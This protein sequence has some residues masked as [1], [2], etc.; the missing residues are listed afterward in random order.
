MSA[1]TLATEF[2]VLDRGPGAEGWM[3]LTVFSAADGRLECM[4]RITAK[5]AAAAPMLDLFDFA[6]ATLE[7]RNQ[8]RTWFVREAL[9]LRRRTGLGASYA[10]LTHACRFARVL[11]RTPVH[12]ESRATVAA[13]LERA[14]DAWETGIRPDA[15]YLKSVFL[16]ARDEGF[17]VREAW[18]RQLPAGDRTAIDAVLRQPAAGQTT[19]EAEVRRLATALEDYLAHEH[20]FVFPTR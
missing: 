13:L 14:L 15:V 16:L 2:H 11:A 3:R 9:P 8:G 4:Q 10:A 12:E 20:D 5:P 6:R 17:P 18:I 7:T 19:P 1:P